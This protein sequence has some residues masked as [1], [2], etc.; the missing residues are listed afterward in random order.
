MWKPGN[1]VTVKGIVY[2]VKRSNFGGVCQHCAL[3]NGVCCTW[4][5]RDKYL[6]PGNC[7]LERVSPIM[8][9]FYE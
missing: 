8:K 6:V 3:N 7:Y 2:R 1:L 5:N 9:T 4:P